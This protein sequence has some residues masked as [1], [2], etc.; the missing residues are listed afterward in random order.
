MFSFKG[1][2]CSLDV[3]YGVLEISKLQFLFKKIIFKFS[4]VK[5][6]QFLVIKTLDSDSIRIWIRMDI[7]PKIPDSVFKI[8]N[9]LFQIQTT[10]F[11]HSRHDL[12]IA[13]FLFYFISTNEVIFY[14]ICR[15]AR[16]RRRL[17]RCT[18]RRD[19]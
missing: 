9:D 19:R 11:S 2:S 8:Q 4:A 7:R 12:N 10:F 5:F 16:E 14:P 18:A 6:F 15:Q 1:L 13:V 17:E 3:L